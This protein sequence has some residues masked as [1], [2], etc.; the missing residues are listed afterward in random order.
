MGVKGGGYQSEL[1]VEGVGY[2]DLVVAGG[3]HVELIL[4]QGLVPGLCDA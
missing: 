3:G 4:E 2:V 1:A